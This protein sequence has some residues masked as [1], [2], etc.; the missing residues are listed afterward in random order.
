MG[1]GEV[2]RGREVGIAI[3]GQRE[4]SPWWWEC[5]VSR[6]YPLNGCVVIFAVILQEVIIREN[7]V[8]MREISVTS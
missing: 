2:R 6:L 7:W 3:K 8:R 5:S 1:G 4:G